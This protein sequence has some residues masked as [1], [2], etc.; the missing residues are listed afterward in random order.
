[1]FSLFQSFKRRYFY[2]KRQAD[3]TYMIEF[4]KDERKLDPK[5]SIFMDSAVNVV[6]VCKHHVTIFCYQN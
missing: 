1:M 6:R 2:L 3:M 4:F 5:G